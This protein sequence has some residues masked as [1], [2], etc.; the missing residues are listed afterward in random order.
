MIGKLIHVVGKAH[1][2]EI[3]EEGISEEANGILSEFVVALNR[4]GGAVP[5]L[6]AIPALKKRRQCETRPF[7]GRRLLVF[8]NGFL[9]SLLRV[10]LL[11]ESAFLNLDA[12]AVLVAAGYEIIAE[13]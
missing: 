4:L 10:G 6:L 5:L 1:R 12:L 7:P 2:V 8:L 13:C 11:F 3:F 9:Q